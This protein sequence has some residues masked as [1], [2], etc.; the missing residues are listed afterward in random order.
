MKRV[1]KFN[2]TEIEELNCKLLSIPYSGD[3][4]TLYVILPNDKQGLESLHDNLKDMKL[5]EKAIEKLREQIVT[6]IIPKFR[7]ELSYLMNNW[8]SDMGIKSLFNKK[9]DLSAI[10]G[11]KNLFVS[12]FIHKAFVDVS[13]EGTEAAA[14]SAAEIQAKSLPT[15]PKKKYQF[16]V[17]HPFA[18]FIRNNINGMII[19][20]GHIFK[21]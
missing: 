12:K 18:F 3:E 20:A 1:G 11:N 2:Y 14:V 21:L 9:A 8:L 10:N 5:I 19:F 4:I 17:D 16:K 15:K 7:I 13:E 6:V